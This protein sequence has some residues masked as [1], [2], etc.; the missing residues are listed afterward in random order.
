MVSASQLRL[1]DPVFDRISASDGMIKGIIDLVYETD[2]GLVIVDYKSD[3][4]MSPDE[5]R[6]RYTTQLLIYKAAI[7]LTTEN[8]VVGLSLYSIELGQEIVIE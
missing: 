7:E 4:G 5:L 6:E 1:G 2:K 3:R 8:K